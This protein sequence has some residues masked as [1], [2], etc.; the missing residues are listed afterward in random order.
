MSRTTCPVAPEAALVA[1]CSAVARQLGGGSVIVAP[2]LTIWH[3]NIGRPIQLWEGQIYESRGGISPFLPGTDEAVAEFV[4]TVERYGAAI[5]TDDR[6]SLPTNHHVAG[7]G[8]GHDDADWAESRFD[9]AHSEAAWHENGTPVRWSTDRCP[10]EYRDMSKNTNTSTDEPDRT[11]SGWA[12][13][14]LRPHGRRRR[15]LR[16]DKGGH[17]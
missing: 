16:S 12:L 13:R 9:P 6:T 5:V 1:E 11:A 15:R 14:A 17:Q 4:R 3:N 10:Q 8:V 2:I 7:V